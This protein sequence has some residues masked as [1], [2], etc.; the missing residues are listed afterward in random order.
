[1]RPLL[2]L[3]CCMVGAVPVQA[4]TP[5]SGDFRREILEAV[6]HVL[7]GEAPDASVARHFR[8]DAV[9]AGDRPYR[10]SLADFRNLLVRSR[11]ALPNLTYLPEGEL[12]GGLDRASRAN[13]EA[14]G[15]PRGPGI[16]TICEGG[17]WAFSFAFDGRKVREVRLSHIVATPSTPP[18]PPRRR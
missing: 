11:C 1:M 6:V 2:L 7:K 12:L 10:W 17:F 13:V 9:F 3:G 18:P 16:G 14:S 8:R 4:A 15:Q 5:E